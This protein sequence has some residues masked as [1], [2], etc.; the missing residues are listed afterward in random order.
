MSQVA[1]RAGIPR[2]ASQGDWTV[3]AAVLKVGSH[4]LEKAALWKSPRSSGAIL[5]EEDSLVFHE[6]REPGSED[7]P[8]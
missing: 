7:G 8:P 5:V 3:A 6:S 2:S 4:R 1:G